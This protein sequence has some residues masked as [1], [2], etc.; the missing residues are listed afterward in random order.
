MEIKNSGMKYWIILACCC[1]VAAS[2]IGI[3]V[4][5]VGVFYTPVSTA[6]GVSQGDF[7]LHATFCLLATAITS[8]LIPQ[9][10]SKISTK[11]MVLIGVLLTAI[12]TFAMGFAHNVVLFYILGTIRGI[13]AALYGPIAVTTTINNWFYKQNGFATSIALCFSGVAGAVL[14]PVFTSLI[15][16]IGWESTYFVVG[17]ITLLCTLPYILYPFKEKPEDEG[18]LP[19]K[20]EAADTNTQE[21]TAQKSNF[22]FLQP[23]F[24][25]FFIIGIILTFLTGMSSHLPTYA[26]S[27]GLTSAAGSLMLS[28]CMVG[29]ICS[30]FLIGL[31]SDKIGII[32]SVFTMVAV[33]ML[34]VVLFILFK[35]EYMSLA[36][37]FLF[38]SIYSVC[39]VGLSLMCRSFFGDENYSS[40]YS[41]IN[42]ASNF[43]AAF[44]VTII[45]YIY[46]FT[47]SY[48]LI[49]IICLV[50][51][52]L[53][54]VGIST[55]RKMKTA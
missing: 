20:K 27:I 25:I 54:I 35:S 26:I 19:Y 37:S 7:T 16:S 34:A 49:F 17:I 5:T 32:K 14:S 8:L 21:T 53:S 47:S 10:M 51:S 11:K 4:N 43:G 15:E 45:G 2:S 42:F 40:A 18:M 31:L 39:A 23:K 6:L 36:A 13:G 44:A 55:I 29:N 33:N 41:K 50:I 3:V 30:K 52:V 24:I 9:V 12:S 1:L 28:A 48:S 46:D 38:G 22:N